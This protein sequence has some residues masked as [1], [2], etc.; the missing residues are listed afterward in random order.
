MRFYCK[1]MSGRF[2]KFRYLKSRSFLVSL[3]HSFDLGL[4]T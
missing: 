1:I 2:H 4:V 3:L